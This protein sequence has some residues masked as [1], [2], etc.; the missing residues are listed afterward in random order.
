[1]GI[2]GLYKIM[3]EMHKIKNDQMIGGPNIRYLEVV[4]QEAEEYLKNQ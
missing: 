4:I 2:K 3:E 1:M